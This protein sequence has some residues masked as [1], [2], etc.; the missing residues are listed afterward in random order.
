VAVPGL[1]CALP[2]QRRQRTQALV[3]L[4]MLVVAQELKGSQQGGV[5][6]RR[7][8]RRGG[9]SVACVVV[10]GHEGKLRCVP[11]NLRVRVC[12]GNHLS[13]G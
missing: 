10:L 3:T 13:E 6:V 9:S 1:T 8:C 11:G 5:L 12:A 4:Q 2:Q 7:A